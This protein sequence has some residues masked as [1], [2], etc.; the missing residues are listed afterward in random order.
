MEKELDIETHRQFW[1]TIAKQHDWY[2]EPFYV[3]VWVDPS[4]NEIYD[5]VSNRKLTE[6][7]IIYEENE[8]W[9]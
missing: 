1:A 8:E 3:Q 9:E 2:Q 4:T 5:S 6:D 7:V